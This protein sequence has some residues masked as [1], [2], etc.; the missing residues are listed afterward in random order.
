MTMTD[1]T[2]NNGVRMP[3]LGL[4]VFQM[5]PGVCAEA[6]RQALQLGY[7]LIDTAQDYKNEEGVG[8]GWRKSGVGRGEIF[9]T[10]KVWISHYGREL[11][12]EAINLSLRKL[13]TDYVD[14]MLLHE[15]Y[16]D[17]YAAYRVL[18]EALKAGKVRAVGVSNF[19]ADHFID[20][21]N[22]FAIPPA[23]NQMEMHVFT[24]QR[25]LQELVRRT[26]TKLMAWGPLAQGKNDIFNNPVLAEIGRAHGKTTAQ[27]ALRF[28]IEKG[29]VV[30]PKTTDAKR[31]RENMEVFDFALSADEQK[32]IEKL[33]HGRTIGMDHHDAATVDAFMQWRYH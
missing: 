24:Q 15:P 33:D 13:Q 31:M 3:R 10:S 4:G 32:A 27:V 20:L 25:E 17:R 14:L 21:I 22:N 2:L 29:A 8:E 6:V 19:Y 18:E 5:S 26:D 1:V 12:A 23:V 9:I 30:V 7:R 28:L 11:T 16:C